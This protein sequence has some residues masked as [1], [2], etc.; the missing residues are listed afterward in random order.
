M[1]LLTLLPAALAALTITAVT[2]TAQAAPA[3]KDGDYVTR[4]VRS[5][6]GKDPFVRVVKVPKAKAVAEAHDC[7]M[8]KDGCDRMM[9]DRHG[10][11]STPKG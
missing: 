2:T 7:P 4:T 3:G 10:H 1:K 8:P 9:G 5:N 11:A 6:N